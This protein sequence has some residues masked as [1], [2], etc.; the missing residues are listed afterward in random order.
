VYSMSP[1]SPLP[2]GYPQSVRA[3]YAAFW[4]GFLCPTDDI[5]E[6]NVALTDEQ[7]LL[8]IDGD[9]LKLPW[10]NGTELEIWGTYPSSDRGL[11]TSAEEAVI[12]AYTRLNTQIA[13]VPRPWRWFQG[14]AQ[15]P[16]HC[17]IWQVP[18]AAARSFRTANGTVRTASDVYV[19]RSPTCAS[20]TL[21]FW[22]PSDPQ[23]TTFA[24]DTGSTDGSLV[25]VPITAPIMFDL[26]SP[27]P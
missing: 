4:I 18:L 22:L 19:A 2:N 6:V 1:I 9:R 3:R 14:G 23:P 7:S 24:I 26:V 13:G 8:E 16:V 12:F 21:A 17:M 20:G 15:Y 27:S 25:M 10:S 11:P 5:R